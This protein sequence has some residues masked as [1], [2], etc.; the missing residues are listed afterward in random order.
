M[1][2]TRLISDAEFNRLKVTHPETQGAC[3]TCRD[4]GGFIQGGTT[5]KCDCGAQRSLQTRYSHAGIGLLYQRMTWDDVKVPE[6][7]LAPIREYLANID[8]YVSRGIGLFISGTVGSGKTLILNLLLKELVQRAYDCYGTT[9]AGTVEAFTSTWGSP[10]EKVHFANRFMRSKVLGLDDLGKEF[11]SSNGLSK[12]TFD[13]ILRTRVQEARPTILTSNLNALEVKTG[14][15]ASV[16]SLLVEQSIEVPLT[17]D[18]YRPHAHNRTITEV[19][20]RETR[21][22]A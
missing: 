10:E 15:G 19:K 2:S 4:D 9:F 21:P 17:G 11:R 18:D 6:A 13:Y 16:L 1:V 12:T 20:S 3:V 22:I 5:R 7:Q 8:E 14:Y